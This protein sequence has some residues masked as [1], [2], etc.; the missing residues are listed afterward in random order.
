MVVVRVCK[1]GFRFSKVHPGRIYVSR[2]LVMGIGSKDRLERS[3]ISANPDFQFRIHCKLY[4]V[5]YILYTKFIQ[6]FEHVFSA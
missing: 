5:L 3:Q 2:Q 4:M 6:H 1:E